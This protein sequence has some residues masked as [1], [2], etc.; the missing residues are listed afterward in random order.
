MTF[1]PCAK[2]KHAGKDQLVFHGLL[3]VMFVVVL[4]G[5]YFRRDAEYLPE[6]H[7]EVGAVVE[8]HL[9]HGVGYRYAFDAQEL[10]GLLEPD[11]P[12]E[13]IDVQSGD[14]LYLAVEVDMAYGQLVAQERNVQV[15]IG[16][17][18]FDQA[19][20]FFSICVGA[21]S[22]CPTGVLRSK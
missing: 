18:F 16:H 12:D 11:F 13:G 20:A 9:V 21:F 14:G 2:R 15:G 17:V 1:S 6:T 4:F 8:S 3:F 5:V 19:C 7:R 10:G 22:C